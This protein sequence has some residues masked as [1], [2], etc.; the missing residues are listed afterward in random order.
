MP[1]HVFAMSNGWIRKITHVF[2]FFAVL[3]GLY[4]ASLNSYVFFHS[5]IEIVT[6]S[7]AF[8][9]AIIIWNSRPYLTNPCLSFIAV[10]YA[11]AGI[12]DLLY[13]LSLI[14]AAGIS[15]E[16]VSNQSAQFW[17]CARF[18]QAF[19]L[20]LAPLLSGKKIRLGSIV[21][22]FAL[23]VSLLIWSVFFKIFPECYVDGK[24]FTDFKILSEY[25][26]IIIMLVSLCG[27]IRNRS[28]LDT[29]VSVYLVLSITSTFLSEIMLTASV[30]FSGFTSMIGQYFNLIAFYYICS[31]IVVTG[32]R[33]PFSL[34]FRD[35]KET[36]ASLRLANEEMEDRVRQ[37]TIDLQNVNLKLKKEVNERKRTEYDLFKSRSML[38]YILNSIPQAIFWKNS[39][40]VFLGCNKN[41]ALAVGIEDPDDIVGKTNFDLRQPQE[42]SQIYISDDYEVIEGKKPKNIIQ[43]F[44]LAD[45]RRLWVN[46]TKV[47][48]IDGAGSAYGILG[49]FE[50]ITERK[51][52]EEKLEMYREHL[53]EQVLIRTA[54]L[55]AARDVA[56]SANLSK[57]QFLA[58]MSHEIRTPLNAVIGMASLTLDTDLDPGQKD[59]LEKI[60][61]AGES[62]LGI[63]NDILD[64]SKIEA[65]KLE[66]EK[67]SF[68]LSD[69]LDTITMLVGLKA[70]DKKLEFIMQ[71]DPDVPKNLVGDSLR[72]GQIL[73]N[74]CNNAV[75]F[76][77]SGEITVSVVTVPEECSDNSVSLCFSVLDTGIGMTKEQTSMLFQPFTQVNSSTT[78]LFGGTGLGLAISRQLAELM[79]GRI[80]VN[81]LPGVGSEFFFTALFGTGGKSLEKNHKNIRDITGKRILVIDDDEITRDS[82]EGFI[83]SLGC[84]VKVAESAELGLEEFERNGGE[85][86]FDLILIDWKMPDMDGFDAARLI[87]NHIYYDKATRVF[88]TSAH[89]CEDLKHR[90]EQEGLDGFLSKPIK[91]QELLTAMRDVQPVKKLKQEHLPW[92]IKVRNDFNT[93]MSGKK[94]LLVEDNR[95]NREVAVGF[96]SR[97]GIIVTVA[98]NGRQALQILEE[99]NFDAVFM[100]I[101]MPVMDG[102]EATRLIRSQPRF[103]RLP[104]IAM[105]AHAMNTDREK[106]VS[107][108]MNDYVTKPIDRYEL[109]A[110]LEKW[111]SPIKKIEENSLSI[112]SGTSNEDDVMLPP[113]LP[114]ISVPEGLKMLIGDSRLYRDLLYMFTETYS[115]TGS[116]IEKGIAI[117]DR[118]YA[119]RLAHSMRSV[120]ATIG[121]I[122]LAEISGKLEQLIYGGCTDG[123]DALMCLFK[124]HLSI[125]IDGLRKEFKIKE[126]DGILVFA[127]S[128]PLLVG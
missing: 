86:L 79:G 16:F 7:V 13:L 71:V 78:R 18:L 109:L 126:D 96:F 99:Q 27:F 57:S 20:L 67:A 117:G 75:K 76:T 108:G 54:E 64:F 124:K 51:I 70:K 104:I 107:L 32:L 39:D 28:E 30:S 14:G 10:G 37:R 53:E 106:S 19:T 34:I 98:E 73:T 35:L 89:G 91:L 60:K 25:S 90:I 121:A 43:P 85:H 21:T 84:Y 80:W 22:I 55:A 38:A 11:A 97:W 33:E 3:T 58:N 59:S 105:T 83:S 24:G 100:D 119:G 102:Y 112:G 6:I 87:K 101:Q 66:M 111:L 120:A 52:A 49:V 15:R 9:M 47:P 1:D 92:K 68:R 40:G 8:S 31:A 48:L 50:D 61:F 125:V 81:S 115:D 63:I 56:E 103:E 5:L 122:E 77:D 41:Y 116:E 42:D 23:L 46:T 65:G 2:V 74:L 118:E 82:F 69:V 127:G 4:Y 36:E 45:G 26:I 128:D 62:L 29:K 110:V 113:E 12:A 94:V 123:L 93:S 44:Q 88:M 17:V 114:G 72:L 95:L